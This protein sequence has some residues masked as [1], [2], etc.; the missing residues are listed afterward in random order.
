MRAF[1][2]ALPINGTAVSA[3][4]CCLAVISL[5]LRLHYQTS[6]ILLYVSVP[7]LSCQRTLKLQRPSVVIL[8]PAVTAE[9]KNASA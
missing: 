3:K 1:L 4:S 5:T 9:T 2:F 8:A 6:Q 7:E